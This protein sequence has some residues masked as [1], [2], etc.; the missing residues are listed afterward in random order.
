MIEGV[1]G[2]TVAGDDGLTVTNPACA[3]PV[4]ITDGH[5]TGVTVTANERWNG[6]LQLNTV[7]GDTNAIVDR[8][9]EPDVPII[10]DGAN[11][12]IC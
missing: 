5:G 7:G 3:S 1:D 12:C 10:F 9:V 6:P 4:A 2:S 11:T 8:T